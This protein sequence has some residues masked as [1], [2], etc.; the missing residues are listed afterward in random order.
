VK[1]D[2]LI[3]KLHERDGH[4]HSPK[5]ADSLTQSGYNLISCQNFNDPINVL[6]ETHID[7]IVSDIHIRNGGTV[8]DFLRWVKRNPA[9]RHVPFVMFSSEPASSSK[10]EEDGLRTSARGLGA[11]LYITMDM[12]ESDKFRQEISSLLPVTDVTAVLGAGKKGE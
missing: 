6:K 3:L 8:F 4:G 2:V 5:V 9:T 1:V 10:Y 7:L 11:S 12:F